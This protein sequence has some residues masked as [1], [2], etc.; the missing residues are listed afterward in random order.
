MIKYPMIISIYN[1]AHCRVAP[2]RGDCRL[3]VRSTKRKA[4]PFESLIFDHLLAFTCAE[5]VIDIFDAMTQF[6]NSELLVYMIS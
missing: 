3:C 4:A 6:V 1:A 5:C 2:S